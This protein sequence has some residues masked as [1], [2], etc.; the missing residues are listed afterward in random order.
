LPADSSHCCASL[1]QTRRL[2]Y[3]HVNRSL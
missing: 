3:I 1:F 2:S